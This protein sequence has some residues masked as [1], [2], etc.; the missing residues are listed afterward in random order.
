MTTAE[1]LNMCTSRDAEVI[2]NPLGA[3]GS[4][5]GTIEGLFFDSTGLGEMLRSREIDHVF[6]DITVS[7][8]KIVPLICITII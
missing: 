7:N 3:E 6:F 4:Y 1:F 5:R 2:M 8:G